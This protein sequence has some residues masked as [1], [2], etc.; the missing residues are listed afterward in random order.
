MDMILGLLKLLTR[1]KPD[2][3]YEVMPGFYLAAGVMT[4]LYFDSTA[5]YVSGS[6]FLAAVLSICFMRIQHRSFK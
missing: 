6:L 5:G 4:M 3:L 2:W 1:W